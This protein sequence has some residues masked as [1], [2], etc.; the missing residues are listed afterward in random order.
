[1]GDTHYASIRELL[2]H[3]VGHTVVDITQHDADDFARDGD[4][5]VELLFDNGQSL[6]CHIGDEGIDLLDP[7]DDDHEED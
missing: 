4:A 3:L 1:M 6:R 7:W 2:G 5:F